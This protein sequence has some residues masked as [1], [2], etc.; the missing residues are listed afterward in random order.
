MARKAKK[1]DLKRILLIGIP[2]LLVAIGVKILD[3]EARLLWVETNTPE[4]TSAR[5]FLFSG[6]KERLLKANEDQTVEIIWRPELD[7]GELE[8]ELDPP[9]GEP[10]F[11]ESDARSIELRLEKG[12]KVKLTVHGRQAKGRFLLKWRSL[13]DSS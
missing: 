1:S 11:L 9:G 5:F 3:D 2:L 8:L 10:F 4:S 7:R 12:E 13:E 6:E